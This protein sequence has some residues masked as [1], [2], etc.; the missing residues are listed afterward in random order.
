M[1]RKV[2]VGTGDESVK[3][4]NEYCEGIQPRRKGGKREVTTAKQV[5]RRIDVSDRRGF[6]NTEDRKI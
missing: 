6:N 2:V 4:R 5:Y 3:V 1:T